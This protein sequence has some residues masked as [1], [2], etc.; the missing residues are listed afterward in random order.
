M[1]NERGN[2]SIRQYWCAFALPLLPWKS[3]IIYFECVFAPLFTQH[4]KRMRR[5]ILLSVASLAVPYYSTLSQRRYDFRGEKSYLAQNACF[6]F[7]YDFY[8]KHFSSHWI[9]Q[10]D[11]IINVHRPLCT[12]PVILVRL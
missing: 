10:R 12:V 8:L 6:G 5:I 9:T 3:S 1:V 4:A 2:L 11:T 7:L